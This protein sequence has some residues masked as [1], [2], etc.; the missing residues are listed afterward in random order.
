LLLDRKGARRRWRRGNRELV[1]IQC[2][3]SGRTADSIRLKSTAALI[4]HNIFFGGRSKIAIELARE[5][6][7]HA[8]HIEDMPAVVTALQR[9]A[10]R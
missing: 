3:P 7:D 4:A 2:F 5:A 6:R 1:F 10:I 8:L 9:R